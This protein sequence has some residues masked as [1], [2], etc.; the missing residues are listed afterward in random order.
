MINV[1]TPDHDKYESLK[2][3]RNVHFIQENTINN[4]HKIRT[5]IRF[6]LILILILFT[7][8]Y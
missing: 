5:E 8:D 3:I 7:F 4:S 1:A 2:K 6:Q